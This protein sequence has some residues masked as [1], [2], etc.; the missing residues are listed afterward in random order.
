MS[1]GEYSFFPIICI[2]F[3]DDSVSISILVRSICI[4]RVYPIKYP[5]NCGLSSV[6][7]PIIVTKITLSSECYITCI[8]MNFNLNAVHISHSNFDEI[9]FG[10]IANVFDFLNHAESNILDVH[11]LAFYFDVPC[12][13]AVHLKC[14]LT[15]LHWM[16]FETAS[17]NSTACGTHF[18][19][20]R[21]SSCSNWHQSSHNI[22][23]AQIYHCNLNDIS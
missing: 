13:K 17:Y 14:A 23:I 10:V 22:L 20:N 8:L 11:S 9:H 19:T 7:V 12:T 21:F 16:L 15:Q 5:I 18:R 4:I 1:C 2:R 6:A 3:C